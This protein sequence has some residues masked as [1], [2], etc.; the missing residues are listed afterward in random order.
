MVCRDKMQ[1]VLENENNLPEVYWRRS[2]KQ[3][4]IDV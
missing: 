2:R 1:I 4:F 3:N